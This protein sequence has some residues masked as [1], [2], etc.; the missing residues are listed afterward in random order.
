MTRWRTLAVSS[1]L[2]L[3]GAAVGILP[4]AATAGGTTPPA[5]TGPMQTAA[6][7]AV[8]LGYSTCLVHVWHPA[9]GQRPSSGPRATTPSGDS[10]A[11]I[12]KAYDFA[13]TGGTGQTIAIVDA[14]GDPTITSN[15]TTFD[16]EYGLACSSCFKKVNQTGGTTYP[17]S[18]P[19]WDLETSLDVEWAHALAPKAH[20]LLV[21]ANTNSDASLFTA[22]SYAASHASYVS[23]SWGGTETTSE[24]VFDSYFLTPGVSFFAAAGDTHSEVIYPSSS[25][26]VVSVGGTTLNVKSTG[27][28]SSETA[29]STA[30]GGCSS[31]ETAN[32]A[33]AS[34]P[35]YDQKNATCPI[36]GAR[37]TPDISLDAN[38]STGVAVYDTVRVTGL[39]GWIQVGGTSASTVMLASHAAETATLVNAAD[40]YGTSLKIYNVTSG[41]N[42]HPCETGYNLC[43]GLGSW[44]TAVGTVRSTPAGTLSFSSAAQKL[45]AGTASA[46]VTVALSAAAPTG[47]VTVKVSSTSSTGE[48]S[49]SSTGPFSTH[50]LTVHVAGGGT[51]AAFYYEDTKAGSPTLTAAAT[52]WNSASQT[53]TVG[54]GT[55]TRIAVSPTS[56][57]VAVGGQ[58]TFAATGYDAY[59]NP[60]T[61]AFDPTWS[62]TVA[63]ASV[64][65][66]GTSTTF[67]AGS[68][69]GS[70]KVTAAVGTVKGTASVS[71]SQAAALSVSVN[72]GTAQYR[73]RVYSVALTVHVTSGSANVSGASVTLDI[74]AGSTCSGSPTA[75][76]SG[77]TGTSGIVN[78]TFS[79]ATARTWCAAATATKAGDT[80]G[81]GTKTF[82]T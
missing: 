36:A 30:G 70:G 58:K 2:A 39:S 59:S 69:A 10:P 12:A 31:Y 13:T 6:C 80:P 22:V 51:S 74:Y 60:V 56:A 24:T 66:P 41:S 4:A 52:G 20:V 78:Y 14:F 62:T 71:V 68:S 18:N 1:S 42:G 7:A 73:R 64:T 3:A 49:A 82:S 77:R 11:T 37:A 79:S 40:V 55:L 57:T 32:S 25:P 19:G 43:T 81:S 53:E 15:L 23:M 5:P 9:A 63:G 26:D 16:S 75:A 76:T 72:A 44:N 47:G 45:T 17:A 8:P 48:F 29:W 27:T 50:T 21:E 35:T 61:T 28:W 65:S 34:Y 46:V 33:Q 67:T 38:P 54:A